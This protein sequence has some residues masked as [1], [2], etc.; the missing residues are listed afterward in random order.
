[1]RQ[2][3]LIGALG[4]VALA[5]CEERERILP[6]QREDLRAIFD[7]GAEIAEETENQTV[8]LALPAPTNLAGAISTYQRRIWCILYFI[9]LVH[10]AGQRAG[11]GGDVS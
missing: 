1:M 7:G 8:A 10:I 6:G 5:G 3:L 11:K 4:L 9:R 2:A